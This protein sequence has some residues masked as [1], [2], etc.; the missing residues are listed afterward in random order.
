MARAHLVPVRETPREECPAAFSDEPRGGA[1]LSVHVLTGA[2]DLLE[3]EGAWHDLAQ[4]A[5]IE[6]P[7]AS[8]EWIR[9]FWE[10]FGDGKQLRLFVVRE[11]AEVIGIAPLMITP[12]RICG[13]P[14]RLLHSLTNDHTPRFDFIVARRT[15]EVYKAIWDAAMERREEWDVLRICQL[16]EGSPTLRELGRRAAAEGY[17]VGTWPSEESPYLALVGG[18]KAYWATHRSKERSRVQARLRKLSQLGP[19]ERQLITSEDGLE[20]VLDEG[21][22]IEASAWKGR[23]GT[24]I[25]SNPDVER[26]YRLLAQRAARSG[27][28]RLSFL[29]AGEGR[30]V[31][32]CYA[33]GYGN[34]V[35]LLKAGYDP[36][37]ASYSPFK[38]LCGLELRAAF[39]GGFSEFDFLGAREDSK[40]EWT[41]TVRRHYW[42]FV[43]PP[44]G[45]ARFLYPLKFRLIPFLRRW[46]DP[47]K[48]RD[49][50]L[51][52]VRSLGAEEQGPGEGADHFT[53]LLFMDRC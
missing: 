50:G 52:L 8:H 48:W 28:L 30:R 34:K 43:F 21:L 12:G 20:A 39:D 18:W 40:A 13:V 19:P 29:A 14:V 38:V 25:L 17:Q 4:R 47:E 44:D 9:T 24:A 22:R 36:A 16:P 53:P 26:F 27:W 5:G 6:H 33:L 37:Y 45:L 10:C 15:Q 46:P 3:L 41:Q 35:R 32:F 31:A 11:G 7:F 42:L 51:G 23:A 2:A 49:L 1:T